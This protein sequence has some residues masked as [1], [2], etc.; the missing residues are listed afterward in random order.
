MYG[1][2]IL[3]QGDIRSCRWV[4]NYQKQVLGS[5]MVKPN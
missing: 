5:V 4:W 2:G 3:K 1:E